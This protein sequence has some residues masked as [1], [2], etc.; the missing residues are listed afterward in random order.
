MTSF[1]RARERASGRALAVIALVAVGACTKSPPVATP[2]ATKSERCFTANGELMGALSAPIE[3]DSDRDLG[4]HVVLVGG[5]IVK[6]DTPRVGF[7]VVAT[8]AEGNPTLPEY[9]YSSTV[10]WAT[11]RTDGT[12]PLFSLDPTAR[13]LTGLPLH[14]ALRADAD[15]EIDG[16]SDAQWCQTEMVREEARRQ[17]V[18]YTDP[19]RTPS[20]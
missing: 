7:V 9:R 2:T 14:P 11:I 10:A 12:A 1:R 19:E 18:H 20:R 6:S 3:Q 15:A 13:F 17:G 16:L 8:V 5:T 4:D